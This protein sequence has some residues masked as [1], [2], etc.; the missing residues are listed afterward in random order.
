MATLMSCVSYHIIVLAI[1]IKYNPLT[2]SSASLQLTSS[3]YLPPPLSQY[4]V[5]LCSLAV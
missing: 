2:V 4:T 5:S 3:P 1:I